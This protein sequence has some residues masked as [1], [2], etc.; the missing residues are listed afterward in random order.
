LTFRRRL[1]PSSF[2]VLQLI[3]IEVT[4][5]GEESTLISEEGV[6]RHRN[7]KFLT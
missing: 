4:L 5:H 1:T 3:S 6:S 2:S 7:V